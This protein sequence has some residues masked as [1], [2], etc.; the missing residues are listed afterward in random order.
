MKLHPPL[1]PWSWYLLA[2]EGSGMN[3]SGSHHC[4]LCGL[5]KGCILRYWSWQQNDPS[6]WDSPSCSSSWSASV[7]HATQGFCKSTTATSEGL[8]LSQEVITQSHD[9]WGHWYPIL[10]SWR[11]LEDEIE[12]SSITH[13]RRVQQQVQSFTQ[14]GWSPLRKE[15]N[16][17]IEDMVALLVRCPIQAKLSGS[18]LLPHQLD[19]GYP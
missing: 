11:L 8:P 2:G 18:W 1:L 12:N 10:T 14:E 19:K 5:Q 6:W 15:Y 3:L 13:H 7:W 9:C 16:A 17:M 4:I